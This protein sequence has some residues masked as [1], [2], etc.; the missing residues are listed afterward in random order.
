VTTTFII[1]AHVEIFESLQIFENCQVRQD[2]AW[3]LVLEGIKS[4]LLS[5]M[6]NQNVGTVLFSIH[7]IK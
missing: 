6:K 1:A 2:R 5:D 4:G 7:K 3:R